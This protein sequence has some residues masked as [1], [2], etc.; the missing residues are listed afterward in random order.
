MLDQV[1]KRERRDRSWETL[2]LVARVISS[3]CPGLWGPCPYRP[4]QLIG[5]GGRDW[6]EV[7]C[8]VLE[9]NPGEGKGYPIQHSGLEN[10]MDCL[11]H[12]VAKRQIW[13]SEFHFH[14]GC[15]VAW[16]WPVGT[17][18]E[19]SGTLWDTR[20]KLSW[21]PSHPPALRPEGL[22]SAWRKPL[23]QTHRL[24]GGLL[25]GSCWRSMT[26]NPSLRVPLKVL[27][28]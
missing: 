18:G 5:H 4:L 1:W 28:Y 24:R 9:R 3:S 21:G 25:P 20:P 23:S 16:I 10:A 19:G 27:Q 2:T 8:F 15:F 13:L 26:S 7:H 6:R 14:F 12:G 11:V 22:D 17:R